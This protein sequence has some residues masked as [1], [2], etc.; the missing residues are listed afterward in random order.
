MRRGGL[1]VEAPREMYLYFL[2]W[3]AAA[4]FVDSILAAW[5]RR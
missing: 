5:V 4:S 2:S 3:E 1:D